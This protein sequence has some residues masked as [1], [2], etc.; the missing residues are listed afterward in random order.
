MIRVLIERRF[1][2]GMEQELQRVLM[3]ARQEAIRIPGYISGETLRDSDNPWHYVVIST[4]R[5]RHAWERWMDSAARRNVMAHI[6]P[7]LVEEERV[8]VMEPV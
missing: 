8:T 7:M 5:S 3:E 4:W 6:S 1:A 2:E